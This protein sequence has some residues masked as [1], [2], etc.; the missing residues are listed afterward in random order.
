MRLVVVSFVLLSTAA[1]IGP[2]VPVI[3][4][5]SHKAQ[6]LRKTVRVYEVGEVPDG[7]YLTLT[8]IQATSCQN[9][10]WETASEE[11]AVN[12]LLYKA[13]IAGANGIINVLCETE[14]TSFSKNCWSSVTCRSAA[15]RVAHTQSTAPDGDSRGRS[16]TGFFVSRD[17]AVLTNSHVVSGLTSIT[18]RVGGVPFAATKIREDVQ[19]D[20]A[21]LRI[22]HRS[23]PLPFRDHPKVRSGDAVIA[24]G[25][26]LSS[27]LSNEQHVTTGTVNALAGIGDDVRFMQISAQLQPGNSG[28]PIL[29]ETGSVVGV[30]V[31]KLDEIKT[32][33]AT[34][35]LPQNVNFAIKESVVAAFLDAV[36]IVVP[37]TTSDRRLSVP[38]ISDSA[39]DSIVF[40]ESR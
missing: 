3:R 38:D 7:S 8:A 6:S 16:G 20:L 31:G 9:K 35:N 21:L 25:Y 29:D 13:S 26:P 4:V 37:P 30:A 39:R 32:A 33:V 24:I 34:G 10:S 17:G 14:G 18:V 40:I 36:G 2:L 22:E 28:G 11:D 15:I 1:C 27:L 23:T 5:D 12:Q 19:N